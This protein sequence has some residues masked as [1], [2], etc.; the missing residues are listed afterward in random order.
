MKQFYC[1]GIFSFK[2]SVHSEKVP[3]VI[4]DGWIVNEVGGI[5]EGRKFLASR[6][7]F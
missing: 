7:R 3:I 1:I 4:F 6:V 2:S 5:I